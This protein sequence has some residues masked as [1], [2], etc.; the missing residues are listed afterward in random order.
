MRRSTAFMFSGTKAEYPR[1]MFAIQGSDAHRVIGD[2]SNPKRLGVGDRAT[3]LQLG[4]EVT[5]QNLQKLFKSDEFDRARPTFERLDL[6]PDR[7]DLQSA[8]DAGASATVSFHPSLPKK[9]DRFTPVVIDA[10]GMANGEGGVIYIG[11]GDRTAKKTVGMPDARKAIAELAEAI[12]A[13]K[14]AL[15]VA[16]TET[17]LDGK[18][19]LR[20]QVPAGGE[21]VV[22]YRV[23]YRW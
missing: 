12:T 8:R 10:C 18:T 5:F 16:V 21:Q 3:E 11:C 6:P 7:S 15:A 20:V 1:R 9:T 19:L 14:P 13:I 22:T 23:R 2:P 4:G 17:E